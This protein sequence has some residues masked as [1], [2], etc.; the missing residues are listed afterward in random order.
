MTSHAP[1]PYASDSA[2]RTPA[3]DGVRG[4]ALLIVLIHNSA[5][6]G[7]IDDILHTGLHAW[8]TNFLERVN[9][10]G[11]RISRNFLVWNA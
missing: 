8:L 11:T 6:I 9:D 7:R 5:W 1:P 3:L 2:A 10:I 4:L